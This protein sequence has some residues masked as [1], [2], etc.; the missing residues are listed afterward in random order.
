[1]IAIHRNEWKRSLKEQNRAA[2]ASRCKDSISFSTNSRWTLAQ[3]R[4]RIEFR[5][6]INASVFLD[7][8]PLKSKGI[9]LHIAYSLNANDSLTW[10]DRQTIPALTFSRSALAMF[11]IIFVSRYIVYLCAPSE[12]PSQSSTTLFVFLCFWF[13]LG[14]SYHTYTFWMDSFYRF[15]P[16]HSDARIK[17]QSISPSSSCIAVQNC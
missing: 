14:S 7:F 5:S 15:S 12:I 9:A 16:L 6:D 1:M 2:T 17:W 3:D 11:R 10:F 8:I 4:S 13:S